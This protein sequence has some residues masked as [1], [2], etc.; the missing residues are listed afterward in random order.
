MSSAPSFCAS[1]KLAKTTL[2]MHEDVPPSDLVVTALLCQLVIESWTN[3][4]MYPKSFQGMERL[5]FS[6]LRIERVTQ[7]CF[8]FVIWFHHM[9][10]LFGQENDLLPCRYSCTMGCKIAPE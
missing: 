3:R 9:H 5:R 10:I 6:L 4:N 1:T 7:L 8:L 2:K